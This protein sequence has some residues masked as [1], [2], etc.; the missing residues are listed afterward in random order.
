LAGIAVLLAPAALFL[1]AC[2]GSDS[3]TTTSQPASVATTSRTSAGA[4]VAPT[5]VT[6]PA[7]PSASTASMPA[8]KLNLNTV[9]ADDLKKTIPNFPDRMVGEFQEYKPYVSIQ[10]FRKEIG[11]YVGASQVTEWEK[12]VFVPVKPNDADA[13]TLKQLPKVDDG[14]AAKLIAA[15]PY[16]NNDAFVAKLTELVP[17]T[18]AAQVKALLG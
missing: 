8:K 3:N 12:Y 9:S 13:E 17:G 18:D 6:N 11:K 15:R 14:V 5:T 10:Q 7:T 16:A 4:D 1:A 2:G